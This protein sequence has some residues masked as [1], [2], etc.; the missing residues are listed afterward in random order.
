MHQH[1]KGNNMIRNLIGPP[2]TG[3][4]FIGREKELADAWKAIEDTNSLL[5]ASPRRVGK[6]SFAM[7]LANKAE[8]KGWNALYLDLQ[9]LKDEG[10]FISLIIR[11]LNKIKEKNSLLELAKNRIQD[12]LNSI[13]KVNAFKITLEL[14]QNPEDFYEKLSKAFELPQRTLIIIDELVLFLEE[15]SRNGDIARAETFLNW[16]RNIRQKQSENVSWVFCSS[17]SIHGFVSQNKLTYTI[18]D[19]APFNLGEMTKEEAT[20]LFEKL[21]ESYGTELSKEDIDYILG[22]IGWKL[23]YFIQLFFHKLTGD[24]EKYQQ[25]NLEDCV[26]KIFLEIIQEHELDTWSERLT[27]YGEDETASR[28]LLNY[29]CL[30]DHK[31][32]RS[33]LEEII[34]DFVPENADINEKYSNIKRMLETDGYIVQDDTGIHFRSPIIQ[35]YW[36]NR[37]IQ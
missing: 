25:M 23:P 35:E 27:A 32:E 16:L 8:E 7:K 13:K 31:N 33:L 22:R 19:I 36:F 17:I 5:L 30:P 1:L 26:N 18:N 14:Q 3:M 11:K 28:K 12:F 21:D 24:K 6:S 29:L 2:V 4:D 10:E 9:G 20:L 37:Y 15:L 34:K